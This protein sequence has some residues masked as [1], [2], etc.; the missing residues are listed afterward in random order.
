MRCQAGAELEQLGEMRL[1]HLRQPGQRAN[2]Q[3]FVEI[4]PD[5]L[6]NARQTSRR[7]AECPLAGSVRGL[8]K[9]VGQLAR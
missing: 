6:D 8:D 4:V 1:A 3:R 2:R 9:G 5:V 7:D